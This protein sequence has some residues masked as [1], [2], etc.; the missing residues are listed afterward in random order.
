MK[1]LLTLAFLLLSLMSNAQQK[2]SF[3]YDDAGN[4]IQ[5][6]MCLGCP[7]KNSGESPKEVADLK[8][9][10]LQKFFPTDVIS[11]YPNPVKEQLYLKW[12]LINDNKVTS[13]QLYSLSGQLVK[14]YN[15]LENTDN[16]TMTFGVYPNGI[17]TLLLLYANGEEKS[18]KI[19]KE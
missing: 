11:Y 4:Q 18:I 10:D 17:Y 3:A 19:I 1:K 7:A 9:E 12:E 2:I 13:I 6:L 16:Q 15:K 8:Q 5:R 14:S